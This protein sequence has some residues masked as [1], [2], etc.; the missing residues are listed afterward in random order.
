MISVGSRYDNIECCKQEIFT[1][2]HIGIRIKIKHL[3]NR[4]PCNWLFY[5]TFA[6]KNAQ[7]SNFSKAR[8]C[9]CTWQIRVTNPINSNYV[10]ITYVDV[11]HVGHD[12]SMFV[13]TPSM[14]ANHSLDGY[15]RG[16]ATESTNEE[17]YTA[18]DLLLSNSNCTIPMFTPRY[19]YYAGEEFNSIDALERQLFCSFNSFVRVRRKA[20]RKRGVRKGL[21]SHWVFYCMHASASIDSTAGVH[22]ELELTSESPVEEVGVMRCNCPWRIKAFWPELSDKIVITY[23]YTLHNHSHPGNTHNVLVPAP[24]PATTNLTETAST[25]ATSTTNI[26]HYHSNPFIISYLKELYTAHPSWGTSGWNNWMICTNTSLSTTAPTIL[27]DIHHLPTLPGFNPGGSG[28]H[29][30]LPR[31]TQDSSLAHTNISGL[32]NYYL[33]TRPANGIAYRQGVHYVSRDPLPPLP[34]IISSTHPMGD[35]SLMDSRKRKHGYDS[36]SRIW[37]D[38]RLTAILQPPVKCLIGNSTGLIP[39]H[40]LADPRIDS[41]GV[42]IPPPILRSPDPIP[43]AIPSSSLSI[44]GVEKFLSIE[45]LLDTVCTLYNTHELRSTVKATRKRGDRAGLPCYW[46]IHCVGNCMGGDLPKQRCPFAIRAYWSESHE[47]IHITSIHLS[48]I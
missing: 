43:I 22:N 23:V 26:N 48:D 21:A 33:Y 7:K 9:G 36:S 39:S 16:N 47:Y 41:N 8:K 2:Y 29:N 30:Q 25:T 6:G 44:N 24:V 18:N 28:S 17:I 35:L 38:N 10:E 31:L 13:E 32:T 1:K 14:L 45:E 12:I 5:C 3:R 27:R 42:H 37:M 40:T 15:L 34:P 11:N 4:V 19:E 46:S 20:K